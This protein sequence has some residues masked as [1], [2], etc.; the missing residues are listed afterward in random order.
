[1]T[2][3]LL[4]F[5]NE[6]KADGITLLAE[7]YDVIAKEYDRGD[8]QKMFCLNYDQIKSPKTPVT[9]ECRGA[10]VTLTESGWGF[11][12]PSVRPLF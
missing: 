2:S 6:H 9:N 5:L 11:L 1:M 10:I 4:C 3:S 8:G 7:T 12:M